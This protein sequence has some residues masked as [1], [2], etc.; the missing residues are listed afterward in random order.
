MCAPQVKTQDTKERHDVLVEKLHQGIKN[1]DVSVVAA[2][3]DLIKEKASHAAATGMSSE[4]LL[5]QSEVK[6]ELRDTLRF[7]FDRYDTSADGLIDE[8]Y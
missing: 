8:R 7:F 5:G 4:T 1:G 2:F 6:R 3:A